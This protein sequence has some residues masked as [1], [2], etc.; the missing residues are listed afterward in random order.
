MLEGYVASVPL[1]L[2]LG[3]NTGIYTEKHF[4]D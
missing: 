4:V 2:I 1:R 3:V